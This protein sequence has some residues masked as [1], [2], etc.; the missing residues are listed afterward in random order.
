MKKT[1][2]GY[3]ERRKASEERR[4]KQKV[5]DAKRDKQLRQLQREAREA[6]WANKAK[7]ADKNR[8]RRD[9]Y[10]WLRR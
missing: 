3:K 4:Y 2:E 6:N 10:D 9:E 1:E 8:R 7:E 5:E